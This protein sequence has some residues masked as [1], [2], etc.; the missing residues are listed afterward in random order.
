MRERGDKLRL[1]ATDLSD[2]VACGHL[3]SLNI[4]V[5]RGEL[6]SCTNFDPL[7]DILAERGRAHEAAYVQFLHDA[8]RQVEAGG[9]DTLAR[10]AAGVEIVTQATLSVGDWHGRIDFLERVAKPSA[11]WPWSY[12]VIDT[13]LATETRAGTVLQLCVYS[14]LLTHAQGAAPARMHVVKPGPE[15]P[16]ES[17]TFDE[18]AA[19]Y[20]ALRED[21]SSRLTVPATTYPEPTAHCDSCRWRSRCDHQR[22]ADDHI[23]LVAD[24]GRLHQREL[25]RHKITTLTAL[26]QA[27]TPWPHRP[28]RGSAATYTRLQQQARLQLT[29]RGLASPPFEL[30][31]IAP[32]RGLTRLPAPDPGDVFLD[33]EGDPFIGANGR[34]YLLGWWTADRGYECLWAIDDATERAALENLLTFLMQRWASHPGMH[35]YHYAPYEPAALKRL[36]GRY[37]TGAD[38]LDRLLRGRRLI[39]LYSITRQATRVGVESYSIKSLEPLVGYHRPVDLDTTGPS[40]RAVRLAL[41]RGIPEAID[42]SWRTHVEAYNRG[43]CESAAALR[44]WL[45]AR[46]AEQVAAG[47]TLTR[48]P[49]LDG[50]PESITEVRAAAAIT[51]GRLL[52]ALPTS[53]D[54]RAPEQ[55]ARWLLGNLMEWY[56]REQAVAWWE[57]F[58]LDATSDAERLEEPQALAGLVFVER[59]PAPKRQ[60]PTDRY[61][62]PP[63]EVFLRPGDK[64]LLADKETFGEIVAID[65]A[66]RTVD[67]KK[68]RNTLDVHPPSA[69]SSTIIGPR[70]KD[71]ALVQLGTSVAD[72]GL[73]A[74]AS[75]SLARDLLTR[76]LPRGLATTNG[77]LRHAGET[78]EACA[79]RLALAL[80]HTVLPMQGPP[81]TGKT[82]TAARMIVALAQAGKRV[83]VT[84]TSHAVLQY[85]VRCAVNVAQSTGQPLRVAVKCDADDVQADPR[86]TYTSKPD[87]ADE[88]VATCDL[89][90]ATPWQ[91]A[92]DTMRGTVDVLFIDEAGQMALAD[93]LAVCASAN[94]LVLV[95]DPQQLEQPIQGTHPDGVAVSVLEHMLAGAPTIPAD[96]GLL[97]DTSHRLHSR[98]CAFT[99][100]QFYERRLQPGPNVDRQGLVTPV[101]SSPGLYWKPV[102]HRGNQNRSLEEATEVAALV[103]QLIAP[104]SQWIDDQG[105]HRDLT[106]AD[107][108]IVAPYNAHVAAIRDALVARGLP[109]VRVGTVDKFQGQEAAIAIYSMAT[110]LPEDAPR[111]LGFLYDRHRLNVATSRARCASIV[112]A[113]PALLRAHCTTPGHLHLVSALARYV[114]LATEL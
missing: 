70:P 36:V 88:L 106:D 11:H 77:S 3:T 92:R 57:H 73:P 39:D 51:A 112:V 110:S 81:G 61:T 28:E 67:V 30:L 56:R 25:E 53:A 9:D 1:A 35:V 95:G 109:G 5:A 32:E 10:M 114:E 94:S 4:A 20:R 62:Y 85:L 40:V 29:G 63:Q 71:L 113:S 59:F 17:F 23:S 21:L 18:Y 50:E 91:W 2:H 80:D 90:G 52:D 44:D 74:P 6:G 108:L 49:L 107:V 100:E 12:E 22:H 8:G 19:I 54:E 86:I 65:P 96:R 72:R 66:A 75:G 26:A 104:G 31:P 34:E 103:R 76:A 16:R 111:G 83:G 38:E 97:L 27:P 87:K 48:P 89:L 43:D 41:Q 101:L 99:S 15:F 98:L 78:I 47:V 55:Q 24:L 105:R 46:R 64:L 60:L 58:R 93:A 33:F 37:A 84:A 13:K 82:W 14:D 7:L 79:R 42:P 69:F 102:T 45:E 68:T